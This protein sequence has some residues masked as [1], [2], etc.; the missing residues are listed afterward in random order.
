[1]NMP[2]IS[3]WKYMQYRVVCDLENGFMVVPKNRNTNHRY[4]RYCHSNVIGGILSTA[5]VS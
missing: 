5:V 2:R 3:P 1:M 4:E